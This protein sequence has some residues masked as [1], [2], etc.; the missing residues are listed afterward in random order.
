MTRVDALRIMKKITKLTGLIAASIISSNG[1][2]V[3]GGL[4]TTDVDNWTTSSVAFDDTVQSGHSFNWENVVVNNVTVDSAGNKFDLEW[5]AEVNYTIGHLFIYNESYDLASEVGGIQGLLMTADFDATAFANWSPVVAVTDGG[6]TNYYRWNH[7]GNAWSGNGALNFSDPFPAGDPNQFDLSQLGNGT[8]TATGI[9]GKLNAISAD[10]GG[11]RINNNGPNLQA[12]TGTIQFGFLQWGGSGG[13]NV[14]NQTF[15]TVIE[16]FEVVVNPGGVTEPIV[17]T[18]AATDLTAISF[19]ANGEVTDTGNEPPNVTIYYG[20]TDGGTDPLS[21]DSMIESGPQ[22]GVFAAT[23]VGLTPNA[24]YFYRA[25][26]TNSA[27]TVWADSTESV[28]TLSPST[29]AVSV[30]PGSSDGAGSLTMNGEVTDSGN[31]EPEITIF[32]GTSDGGTNPGAWDEILFVGTEGGAF[33]VTVVGLEG[34]TTYFYRAF[35]ENSGGS[36]FSETTESGTT[37][38][39]FGVPNSLDSTSFDFQYEMDV[40][41]SEQDLD[42]VGSTFDWWIN[43]AQATGVDQ[44]MWI[45]QT[46]AAGIASSN[47]NAAPPEALFRTDYTASISRESLLGDFT[48]E[49]ALQLKAGTIAFPDFDLGGFGMFINP[50]DQTAFRLNINEDE[51]ST[52]LGD[53]I[54]S[55]A[56]NTGGM[57]VFRIAYVEADQRFWVWRDGVLVYGN[58]ASPGGGVEGSEPSIYAGGGF[59]L[60]DFAGDLSGD[61]DVDYIRLH[62]EAVAPTGAISGELAVTGFGFVD[63]TTVFID[64]LGASSRDHTITSS[65]NLT[66]FSTT[67]TP[68][69][70]TTGMTN[71][72]GV[73]RVEISVTGRVVDQLFF[74]VE[75]P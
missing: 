34:D 18:T 41:P 56:N 28:T 60:G 11:T 16:S 17:V 59:L 29:P 24:S 68:I 64:F 62:N 31:E 38:A 30:L 43:Q 66:G 73:G 9:W 51:L 65:L 63:A 10:F 19:S 61:W 15:S 2:T 50:P 39:F 20:A 52:G 42:A 12:A 22:T 35:A 6:V 45:P 57:T 13:G 26:A 5:E 23:I 3:F 69:N 36:V 46:Y 21:W 70:G 4:D 44:V 14:A 33:S 25:Q 71:A 7:S 72:T 8:N 54:A 74:R 27:G 47:Q 75:K 48:V 37:Q 32:Y 55:T 53:E 40:N 58:T 1:E 49:V 67:E